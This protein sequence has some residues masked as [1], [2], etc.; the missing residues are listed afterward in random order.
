MHYINE[1]ERELY[2]KSLD[3]KRNMCSIIL[4]SP[5]VI[6]IR[7]IPKIYLKSQLGQNLYLNF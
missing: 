4:E 3:D 6:F 5:D 1:L 2:L 7:K